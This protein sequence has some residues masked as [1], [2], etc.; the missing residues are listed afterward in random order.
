ML[1]PAA[2]FALDDCLN[3]EAV[4]PLLQQALPAYTGSRWI[5]DKVRVKGARRSSSRHRNPVPLTLR[6]ELDVRDAVNGRT[7]QLQFYGK[8]YRNGASAQAA[9]GAPALHLPQLDMLLWAWPADPGLPQLQALL[10]PAQTQRWWGESAQTVS[11]PRYQPEARATLCYTRAPGAKG[12]AATE[13]L[14]AKTFCDGRAALIHQRFAHFWEIACRDE[15]APNVAQPLGYC[16]DTRAFWQAQAAG[17]PLTRA[18]VTAPSAALAARLAEA[19]AAVHAAPVTLAGHEPHDTGHWLTE[20]R[21]R[22]KKIARVAP[23]LADCAAHVAEVLQQAS[24]HLP[25]N[26]MTL[27]HGDCHPDQMWLDGERV[28][29]FDFDEFA[30][31]D[32]MED[33]AAFVT[34]LALMDVDGTFSTTL[35][36]GVRRHRSAALLPPAA[37]MASRDPAIAA[38]HPC[39]HFSGERLARRSQTSTIVDGD[40]MQIPRYRWRP[41]VTLPRFD[42]TSGCAA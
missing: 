15:A 19:I 42:T 29:L 8:V 16:D 9:N 5:V 36:D 21:L 35:L 33:L 20:I 22:H 30:L 17:V 23:E 41:C 28:V 38:N 26:P 27:I 11:V 25:P 32:P 18:L 6:Y 2:A 10:D 12:I 13:A 3:P 4:R 31:G 39:L 14:Y 37:A 34:K 24:A 7:D 1:A 40:A